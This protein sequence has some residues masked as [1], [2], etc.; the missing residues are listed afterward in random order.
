MKPQRVFCPNMACHDKYQVGKGNIVSHGK[1]RQR[2]KC[3]SCGHTFSYRRGTMFYG[4]RTAEQ[5][6]TWVVGLVAWGCQVAAIVAV[7]GTDERTVADW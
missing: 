7:F 2:C 1:G 6:V 3:K 5:V 4:L